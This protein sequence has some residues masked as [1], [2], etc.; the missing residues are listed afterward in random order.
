MPEAPLLSP[1][2]G[3]TP[4]KGTELRPR[5]IDDGNYHDA[6]FGLDQKSPFCNALHQ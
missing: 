3:S 6:L 5:Q 1:T 2:G 4:G